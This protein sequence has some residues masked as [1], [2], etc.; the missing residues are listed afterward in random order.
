MSCSKF[1]DAFKPRKRIHSDSLGNGLLNQQKKL[2]KSTGLPVV[3]NKKPAVVSIEDTARDI[4]CLS[5]C[6]AFGGQKGNCILK[7]F[8]EAD[9]KGLMKLD[10]NAAV[11]FVVNCRQKLV[12]KNAAKKSDY[13]RELFRS[14]ISEVLDLRSG[15]VKFVMDYRIGDVKVCKKGFACAHGV[16]VGELERASE[17][18][19]RTDLGR[20]CSEGKIR[21]WGDGT[22]HPYS[23][24]QVEAIFSN[25]LGGAIVG[26]IFLYVRIFISFDSVVFLR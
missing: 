23:Y 15:G 19:K 8:T 14:C 12:Y 3:S 11:D 18:C 26:T 6:C 25:N 20:V 4:H 5:Q 24:N 17:N 21:K 22:V 7:N 13:I 9:D 1:G 10:H 2:C 16:S